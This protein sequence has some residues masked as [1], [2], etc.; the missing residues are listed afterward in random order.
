MKKSPDR[1]AFMSE[2]LNKQKLDFTLQEG[3]DGATYNFEGLC[4]KRGSGSMTPREKAIALSHRTILENVKL[5]GLDYALILED[6]VELPYNFKEIIDLEIS[7]RAKNITKWEYLSFNY[8]TV[9]LHFIRLWLFLFLKMFKDNTSILF[10]FK[11]PFYLFKFIFIVIISIFEKIREEIYKKL[12]KNGKASHFY[13]PL[14]L[15]GCYLINKKGLDKLLLLNNQITYTAD[16]LPNIAR[17]KCGL[18]FYA[19]VPLL[20]KQRRDKFY[21]NLSADQAFYFNN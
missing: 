17:I 1:L 11:T 14:Y 7:K 12:Y 3:F 21:S 6:D 10:Y 19:F 16:E 15:A 2:Q 4:S 20:V 13:R 5:E 8:P 18:K 9:G